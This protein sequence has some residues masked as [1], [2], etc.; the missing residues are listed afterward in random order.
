MN[1]VHFRKLDWVMI[2]SALGLAVLGLLSLYS[3]SIRKGDFFNFQK[4]L[5]FLGIGLILL[6]LISFF[7]YRIL[8][9]N[10]YIILSLYFLC[11]L[12]LLGVLFLAPEIRG[13]HGWYKLGFL[14]FDPIEP[15]KIILLVLLAKYFSMR[16]VEMYRFKHIVL[17]G[18]YVFLPSVLIFL[19]PDMGAVIILVIVWLSTLIISGI[20]I[21]HFLILCLIAIILLAEVWQFFLVDYQ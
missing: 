16:H 5:I 18:I 11:L 17:S 10:P 13:K 15:A 1:L 12:A 9:N 4:Q 21:K 8:R 2:S 3:S 20:K 19:Q 6:F 14:S 7:D